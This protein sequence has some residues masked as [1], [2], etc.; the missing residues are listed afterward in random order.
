MTD[1]R[2]VVLPLTLIILM[3]LTSLAVAVT[4][5]GTTEPQISANLVAGARARFAAEAGLEWAF[6]LLAGTPDWSTLLNGAD[7]DGIILVNNGAL[8]GLDPTSGTY[9]IR[10]R[11]DTLATDTP[12]TGVAPDGGGAAIDTNGRVIVVATGRYRNAVRTVQ[13]MMRR[14]QFPNFPAALAFPGNEAQANFS[15]NA[16]EV[17]GNDFNTD[18]SPGGCAPVYGISVSPTL[19]SPPGSNE[20]VVE[21]ALSAQ[22]KDNVTGKKQVAS[23]PAFG[24]NTVAVE[25]TLTPAM[26]K[27]FID[28]AKANADITLN[29]HQPSGLSFSN[30][31]NT[32]SADVNSQTCWGTAS[33][34]KVVYIKGDFDPTSQFSALQLSGHTE[35]YGVLIV[36]DGDLRISGNFA[37]NGPIIVTGQYVGIGFLGGGTQAVYGAVIS[38][39]TA[40]DPGFYEGVVTGNS[41]IRY[42]C[43]ALN[44]AKSA[45]RLVT[46]SS[47]QEIGQ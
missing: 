17:S 11:N 12:I 38:N 14:A 31:G 8:P 1:Q 35:G 3:V 27:A 2:G 23:G 6:D 33:T 19:G 25:P 44:Q 47:W 39:E 26:V 15:G 5:L 10:L 45:R 34:P 20:Q 46:M 29:S 9:T 24:N 13:V 7:A 30:I 32:C 21:N 36:E 16:F 43:Q 37:W 18:G 40:A 41:T 28:A 4:V 22:Q 42:S